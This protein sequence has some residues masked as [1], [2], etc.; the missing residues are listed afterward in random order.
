MSAIKNIHSLPVSRL[1][2][3]VLSK[4]LSDEDENR[5]YAEIKKRLSSGSSIHEFMEYEEE[6]VQ[7]RGNDINKYLIQDNPDAQLLMY[8]YFTKVY[9]KGC[10]QHGNLMYSENMLCNSDSQKSFFTKFIRRELNNIRDRIN[11]GNESEEDIARLKL[12]QLCLEKRYNKKQS[13]WYENS[14]T[15]CVMDTV[16]TRSSLMSIKKEKNLEA[17]TKEGSNM[18]MAQ[19]IFYG[20]KYMVYDNELLDYLNMMRVAEK[21]VIRLLKQKRSI[22]MSMKSPID[23]SFLDEVKIESSSPSLVKRK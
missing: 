4:D 16:V 10:S 12:A 6:A 3:M 20:V 18:S 2:F 15:D 8:L 17:K 19:A 22:I 9:N 21:D 13:P 14:L 7:K 5:A 1:S 11:S 23:Y